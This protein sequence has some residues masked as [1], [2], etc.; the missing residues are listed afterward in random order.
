MCVDVPESEEPPPQ[1]LT[2]M[3]TWWDVVIHLGETLSCW[4]RHFPGI[5]SQESSGQEGG[6]SLRLGVWVSEFAG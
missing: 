1:V 2:M 6:E 4:I 5:S 3:W